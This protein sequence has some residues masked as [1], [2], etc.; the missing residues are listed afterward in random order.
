MAGNAKLTN[1]ENV[2][3]RAQRAGDLMSNRNAA[4]RK[5]QHDDIRS[6]ANAPGHRLGQQPT[7]LNT[8]AKSFLDHSRKG[9]K[10]CSASSERRHR[11]R[12]AF[13]LSAGEAGARTVAPVFRRGFSTSA[14]NWEPA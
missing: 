13:S 10:R 4:T 14:Q 12:L 5:C 9:C 7:S 11:W 2:E 8:V 3:R 6:I 1:D